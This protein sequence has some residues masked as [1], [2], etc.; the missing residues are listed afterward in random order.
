MTKLTA[1]QKRTKIKYILS[2]LDELNHQ[3]FNRMYSPDNLEQDVNITVDNMPAA[4]L[5]W[6]LVQCQNTYYQVFNILKKEVVK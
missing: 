4:Q 6:A 2:K 3:V 5:T 1:K